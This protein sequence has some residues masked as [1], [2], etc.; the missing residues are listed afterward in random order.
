MGDSKIRST[1]GVRLCGS[2]LRDFGAGGHS[3]LTGQ[4][5]RVLH[6][7]S[8]KRGSITHK[9]H[10][11]YVPVHFYIDQWAPHIDQHDGTLPWPEGLTNIQRELRLASTRQ[12]PTLVDD[13]ASHFLSFS[14][15]PVSYLQSMVN[16]MLR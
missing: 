13:A 8:D 1:G 4:L 7:S 3:L 11:E 16:G 14:Q 15:L 5:L 6:S 2:S 12:V 10:L 9:Q